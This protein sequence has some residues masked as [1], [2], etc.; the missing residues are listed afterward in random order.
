MSEED[1]K[2]PEVINNLALEKALLEATPQ[3]LAKTASENGNLNR[4]K[5][6]FYTSAAS[7]FACH[8]P[9]G[10]SPRLGPDLT[11]ITKSMQPE[12]WVNSVLHPSKQI[13][14]EFAQV[15]VVT[16]DGKV[17]TGIRIS[18]DDTGVVLRNVAEPKPI[19]IPADSIDEVI[20]SKTSIMPDGLVRSLKSR[21]E[22][23][24]LMKYLISLKK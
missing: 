22:F 23:D 15:N 16:D 14:K 6:L 5:R 24:D 1:L 21:Q 9:P 3:E 4:G 2:E 17:I 18:E 12:D 11:K 8:D 19:T 20:E 13:D 7:C 10:N